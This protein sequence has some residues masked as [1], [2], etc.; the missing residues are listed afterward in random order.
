MSFPWIKINNDLPDHPKSDALASV[1]SEP[2]AW[3]Y[4]VELW[5]WASRTKPDGNLAGVADIIIAKR[6]GWTGDATVFVEAL[7]ATGWLSAT[8]MLHDWEEH[9]GAVRDKAYRDRERS[10]ERR[11]G[12]AAGPATSR[13]TGRGREERRGEEKRG[14]GEGAPPAPAPTPLTADEV[15]PPEGPAERAEARRS[16]AVVQA[17]LRD[18][19]GRS[20]A[21]GAILGRPQSVDDLLALKVKDLPDGRMITAPEAGRPLR[22]VLAERYPTLDGKGTP[23][24]KT[25]AEVGE[26]LWPYLVNR[27]WS[28]DG[29]SY[30]SW[31]CSKMS[32]EAEKARR[33]WEAQGGAT[34]SDPDR[35]AAKKRHIHLQGMGRDLPPFPTW[36]DERWCKGLD[37]R[38]FDDADPP[39][40]GPSG[41]TRTSGQTRAL[42][43]SLP[44]T[45]DPFAAP[46]VDLTA[47]APNLMAMVEANRR[48]PRSP[49]QET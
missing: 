34:A 29:A 2:R 8:R 36:Y 26:V 33:A 41:G 7:I 10:E 32:E 45:A 37:R 13:A 12:R 38:D 14:E 24:R 40:Q 27:P 21:A 48:R 16:N 5:L 3:T 42:P 22:E 15:M 25:V 43:T 47:K 9:Q 28:L 46:G 17:S 19:R 44:P 18:Y 30:L 1:L 11:A 31:L 35:I 20:A 39:P 49:E 4:L 6:A 23:K